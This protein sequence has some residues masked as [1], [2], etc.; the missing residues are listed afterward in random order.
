[1]G[2]CHLLLGRPWQFDKGT[3]HDGITNRYSFKHTGKRFTLAPLTPSQ[4][5][6]DQVRLRK[7]M[8]EAKEKKMNVYASNNEI[9]KCLSSRQSIFLLLFCD[10]CYLNENATDLLASIS[11]LL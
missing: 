11:S 1:M 6:E 10:A 9:R 8:E 4:V 5:Q 2:A 7:N 3:M